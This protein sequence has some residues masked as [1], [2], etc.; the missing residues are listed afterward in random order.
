[1]LRKMMI[2]LMTAG[3]GGARLPPALWRVEAVEVA[4]VEAMGVASAAAS[5]EPT[6]AA[7]AEATSEVLA[8]A[9][10]EGSAGPTWAGSG[11]LTWPMDVS[12]TGTGL[13]SGAIASHFIPTMMTTTATV[14]T[15]IIPP[16]V[17]T[18]IVITATLSAEG[19]SA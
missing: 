10:L 1:M 2:V 5:V 16:T 9:A 15:D 19:L 12:V 6:W 14:A 11:A 8:E 18:D 17:A 3:L 4:A 13:V 7:S